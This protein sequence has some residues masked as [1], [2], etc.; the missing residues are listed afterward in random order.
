MEVIFDSYRS[1]VQRFDD[2]FDRSGQLLNEAAFIYTSF[3]LEI[4]KKI[5]SDIILDSVEVPV[6]GS[7]GYVVALVKR[8]YLDEDSG[9]PCVDFDSGI[10]MIY[11]SDLNVV[12]QDLISQ[13]IF[14]EIKAV[15]VYRSLF[16]PDGGDDNLQ[17]K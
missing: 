13:Y 5:Q 14:I 12:A 2:L 3:V 11:F 15:D 16:Q 7:S 1:S 8:L 4:L 9:V 6:Y 10:G 17:Q